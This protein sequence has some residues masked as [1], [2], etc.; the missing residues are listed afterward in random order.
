DMSWTLFYA[1]S[2]DY[3]KSMGI[4]LLRGRQFTAQDSEGASPVAIIDEE[5]AHKFFPTD[6]PIGK[7]MNF[8]LLNMHAQ[9]VGI[10]RHVNQW[11]FG[12]SHMSQ[13][14]NEVY[15]PW[16]QFPDQVMPLIARGM[17]FTVRTAVP[18]DAMVGPLRATLRQFDPNQVA[19]NFLPMERV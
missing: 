8:G 9:I 19:Y 13:I 12:M 16:V 5:L 15:M 18:P 2:P 17:D 10:V 11:G 6:D 14:Q 7:Q 3:F 1:I 4:T